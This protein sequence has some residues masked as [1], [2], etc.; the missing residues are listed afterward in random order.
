MKGVVAGLVISALVAVY[1][2]YKCRKIGFDPAARELPALPTLPA[3]S[4]DMSGLIERVGEG[5]LVGPESLVVAG[6]YMFM[7]LADG[8]VVRF[9]NSSDYWTV[10][11]T[12][13]VRGQCP[14][15]HECG[16]SPSDAAKSEKRCGRPLGMRLGEDSDSIVLADAYMGLL[17]LRDPFSAS[18]RLEI[19]A[20]G[21]GLV[22][23]VAI[24]EKGEI[25]FTETSTKFRRRRI[26][27]SAFELRA[28][29]RLLSYADGQVRVILDKVANPNGVEYDADTKS[30]L[31]V[32]GV[33]VRRLDLYSGRVQPFVPVLP[34]TG[35]NLRAADALPTGEPRKCYWFGLGS[36]YTRPFNLLKFFDTNPLARKLVVALVPYRILVEI[37]PK[38]TLLAVYDTVG[39]LVAL[40]R[41]TKPRAAVW[42]SEAHVF[43]GYLYL[44]SWYNNFLARVDLEALKLAAKLQEYKLD[45]Y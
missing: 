18:P 35:D 30:L 25:F 23:D 19:L 38:A 40:Y 13:A 42:L 20:D 33:S 2:E 41:D 44:A 4:I 32:S 31:F 9:A 24:G 10:A 28:T 45:N 6:G 37:V 14:P 1:V 8:R 34:G 5:D 15:L 12:C 7:G 43:D 39:R 36:S 22:N 21:L 29:G 16:A 3:T 11:R 27:W 26:F 17:V